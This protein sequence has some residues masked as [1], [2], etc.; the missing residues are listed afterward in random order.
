MTR[1][2]EFR[3][4]A[5]TATGYLMWLLPGIAYASTDDITKAVR[6]TSLGKAQMAAGMGTYLRGWEEIKDE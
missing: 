2:K 1:A 3:W 4:V 6:T 5:K